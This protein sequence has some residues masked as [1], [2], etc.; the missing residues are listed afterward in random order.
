MRARGRELHAGLA[1]SVSGR[2]QVSSVHLNRNDG[3]DRFTCGRGADV[4]SKGTSHTLR[5]TVCTSHRW[6]LVFSED[7]V[8]GVDSQKVALSA[9]F[10]RM[11]ELDT[12]RAAQKSRVVNLHI[13]VCVELDHNIELAVA[14][15]RSP[16]WNWV[17]RLLG[18][19][20]MLSTSIGWTLQTAVHD[21]WFTC[22]R[23]ASKHPCDRCSLYHISARALNLPRRKFLGG[24]SKVFMGPTHQPDMAD[25]WRG[26][27]KRNPNING[28]RCP[29]SLSSSSSVPLPL[30]LPSILSATESRP[31]RRNL[32]VRWWWTSNTTKS[33]TSTRP[34]CT[35]PDVQDILHVYR[36]C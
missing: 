35:H 12:T 10:F 14:A 7:V 20:L 5:N 13:I 36:T 32:T 31:S 4:L 34:S 15:R 29:C 33:N 26:F 2:E 9:R 22:H 25:G 18:T 21:C 11:V 6:L 1:Q 27:S 8:E 16:T 17:T 30:M 23:Y 3:A 19:P 28:L 24:L